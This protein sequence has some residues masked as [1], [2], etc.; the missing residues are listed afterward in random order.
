M[1]PEIMIVITA[2]AHPVLQQTFQ[3]R[4]YPVLY[5]PAITYLELEAIAQ[6]ITGLVVTTR[7]K[8]DKFFLEKAINLKWIGRLGSG[9]ELIDTAYASLK[10]IICISTPEG[11]RNAVGEQALGMLLGL[12]HKI[13]KSTLEVKKSIWL[14]EENRGTELAGKKVGIIGFGNT[15]QAFAKLLA[16]FNVVVLANDINK[17]NFGNNYIEEATLQGICSQADVISFHVPLTEQT[18]YMANVDF[19]DSLAKKPF[20]INTSRGAVIN[21]ADL[22][23]ALKKQQVGG[24]ALDVLENENIA[25]LDEKMSAE[26]HFLNS[27]PDVIL[28]P[29]IAGYTNEAFY[30]MSKVLLEKLGLVVPGA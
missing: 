14:R 4:G 16:P 7:I 30:K 11:N 9:M 1:P 28:T 25:N 13:C 21:T 26:F 20:I 12:M 29:H 15:G 10:K 23:E 5:A 24:V 17:K 6:E 19:F 18:A 22:I 2:N 8:I 27:H 3:E